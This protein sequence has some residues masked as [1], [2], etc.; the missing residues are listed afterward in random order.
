MSNWLDCLEC[1]D[2]SIVWVFLNY[3]ILSFLGYVFNWQF[4]ISQIYLQALPV[5]PLI[6]FA[7]FSVY[8]TLTSVLLLCPSLNLFCKI[9]LWQQVPNNVPSSLS[10]IPVVHFL[11]HF[12]VVGF[13]SPF[14]FYSEIHL[15][16]CLFPFK[17]VLCYRLPSLWGCCYLSKYLLNCADSCPDIIAADMSP[18][19]ACCPDRYSCLWTQK[20]NVEA[21]TFIGCASVNWVHSFTCFPY[22]SFL[23]FKAGITFTYLISWGFK[24]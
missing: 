9:L 8:F 12:C 15:Q 19:S 13:S 22:I 17:L 5:I 1:F 4:L 20:Q 18:I 10:A 3:K 23:F 24:I 6:I 21:E 14:I 2:C 11:V 7:F 16:S